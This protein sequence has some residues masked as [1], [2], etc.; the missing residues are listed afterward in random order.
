[1]SIAADCKRSVEIK[2]PLEEVEK[3]KERVTSSLRQRVRLPGFRPGKAPL[4]MIQSRFEGDIDLQG[5]DAADL[6]AQEAAADEVTA[7][8][9]EAAALAAATAGVTPIA[10]TKAVKAPKAKVAKK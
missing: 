5:V 6:E 1:M 9:T 8:G 10:E 2:I 7:E 4:S 3:T